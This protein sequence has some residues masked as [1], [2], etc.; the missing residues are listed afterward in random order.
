M[1]TIHKIKMCENN[2][3]LKKIVKFTVVLFTILAI[4]KVSYE[5]KWLDIISGVFKIESNKT[6]KIQKISL[7]TLSYIGLIDSESEFLDIMKSMNW[8]FIKHY[9]KGM[10]FE[11]EGYEVL[12]T[13]RNY[14]NRYLFFEV[15]TREIFDVI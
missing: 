2:N 15:T 9:G 1:K 11:K 6:K 5:L 4:V 10:I 8:N 13:K 3:L 12:I 7:K 14:F